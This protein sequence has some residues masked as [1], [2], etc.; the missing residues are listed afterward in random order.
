[1]QGQKTLKLLNMTRSRLLN[2]QTG[3]K[4]GDFH[5]I[6]KEKELRRRRKL[7]L[8]QL[9]KRRHI[10]SKSRASPSPE[11]ER[12]A[13]VDLV[14]FWQHADP[15][16]QIY[17]NCFCFQWHILHRMGMEIRA[18]MVDLCGYCSGY[19][20]VEVVC[21]VHCVVAVK[22]LAGQQASCG[23]RAWLE[24]WH[25]GHLQLPERERGWASWPGI[26]RTKTASG[27]LWCRAEDPVTLGKTHSGITWEML[28][29]T[30]TPYSRRLPFWQASTPIRD[31]PYLPVLRALTQKLR[32]TP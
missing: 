2:M 23:C 24:C 13:G 31:E 29:G 11:S 8:H 7:S 16:H 20:Q 4:R 12:E 5:H 15:G 27:R 22:L 3:A 6:R 14:G 1:M 9:R 30:S 10:C 19:L 26:K 21:K 18:S 17:L 32:P 25:A 28:S